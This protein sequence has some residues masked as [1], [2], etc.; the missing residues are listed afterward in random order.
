LVRTKY[1]TGDRVTVFLP[2]GSRF[3][4]KIIEIIP[5]DQYNYYLV[6]HMNMYALV[7]ERDII[8][9]H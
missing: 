1:K 4:G 8:L 7:A 9:K 2:D 6:Q 3:K 5:G